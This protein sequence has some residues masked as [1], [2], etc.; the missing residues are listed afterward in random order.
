MCSSDLAQADIIVFLVSPDLLAT[1]Y[2]IDIEIPAAV[3]LAAER[4]TLV[5]PVLWRGCLWQQTQLAPFQILPEKAVPIA[6]AEDA[7]AAWLAVAARLGREV[8]RLAA[9]A[10]L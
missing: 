4:G 3:R 10:A 2:V 9:A 6:G 8:E 1:P 5:L 7:D